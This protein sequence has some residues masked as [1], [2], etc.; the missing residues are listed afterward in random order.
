MDFKAGS[1]AFPSHPQQDLVFMSSLLSALC[2][3][4]LELPA[5]SLA[6]NWVC[7]MASD[8]HVRQIEEN[9]GVFL[10]FLPKA[11]LAISVVLTV[12]HAI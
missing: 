8:Y 1:R 4:Y 3:L 7:K 11:T 5:L 2:I 9:L 10:F 6:S 12:S